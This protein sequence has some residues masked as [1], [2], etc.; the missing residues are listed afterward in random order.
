MSH[1]EKRGKPAVAWTASHFMEDARWSANLWGRP[2]L[3]LIEVPECFTNNS[4]D[5]IRSMVDA[6]TDRVIQR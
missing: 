1:T 2:E 5:N 3:G 4:P 6:A